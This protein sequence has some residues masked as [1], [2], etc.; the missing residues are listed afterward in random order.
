VHSRADLGKVNINAKFQRSQQAVLAIGTNAIPT[1]LKLL[2]AQDTGVEKLPHHSE[3]MLTAREQHDMAQAGFMILQKQ[4]IGAVPELTKL[5]RDQD[6][7]VRMRAFESL[8]IVVNP[9]FKPLVPV[10]VPFGNDPDSENRKKALEHMRLLLNFLSPAEAESAE[11]YKAFPE[12][13]DGR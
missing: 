1:L 10:L 3:F 6:P 4:A 7:G 13:R 2:Q 12:L 11:V 5:T 9:D 8:I